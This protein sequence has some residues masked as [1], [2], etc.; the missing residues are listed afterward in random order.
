MKKKKGKKRE[1][2]VDL[3]KVKL[4]NKEIR[5]K[6]LWLNFFSDGTY[7]LLLKLWEF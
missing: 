6:K 3:N 2:K 5:K 7:F 1:K 4:P